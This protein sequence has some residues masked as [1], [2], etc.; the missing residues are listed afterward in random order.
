MILLLFI[1]TFIILYVLYWSYCIYH[2]TITK[3]QS[4]QVKL[5]WTVLIFIFPFSSLFYFIATKSARK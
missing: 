5:L 2:V 1:L 4:K 3:F